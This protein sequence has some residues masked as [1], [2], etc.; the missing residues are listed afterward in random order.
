MKETELCSND[1]TFVLCYTVFN[2]KATFLCIS[3]FNNWISC[4]SFLLFCFFVSKQDCRRYYVHIG[5]NFKTK[6]KMLT[7]F[8][9][10]LKSCLRATPKPSEKC[11]PGTKGVRAEQK[12]D[13]VHAAH[14]SVAFLGSL[15]DM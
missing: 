15:K 10:L 2:V 4:W 7:T 9:F 5:H 3:F 14:E 8:F 6:K 12:V 1:T 13:L 11:H